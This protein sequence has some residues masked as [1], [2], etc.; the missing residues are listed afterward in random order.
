MKHT[1]H[2]GQRGRLTSCD[3]APCGGEGRQRRGSVRAMRYGVAKRK[4]MRHGARR[5]RLT[6]CDE[7]PGGGEERRRR[8]SVSGE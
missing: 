8:G 2:G 3:E 4:R 7:A 1:R 6:C 5:G